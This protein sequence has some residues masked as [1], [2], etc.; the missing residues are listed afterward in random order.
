MNIDSFTI[1]AIVVGFLALFAMAMAHQSG[2]REYRRKIAELA[3]RMDAM[4]QG[5][6]ASGLHTPEFREL[7]CAIRSLYP[8]A[9]HG[10]DYHIGDDG[11]GPYIREWFFEAPKPDENTLKDLIEKHRE[12]MESNNYREYRRAAY[13]PIEEQLDAIHKARSGDESHLKIIE[14]QIRKVKEKYPK[15]KKCDPQGCE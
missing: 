2:R 13:P 9:L 11:D 7:C 10:V 15:G 4:H 6:S 12:E 1:S 3:R 14:E 5:Q 8:Q